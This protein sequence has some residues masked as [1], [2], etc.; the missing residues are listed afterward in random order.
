MI[1]TASFALDG[2]PVETE[3][4]E[5]VSYARAAARLRAGVAEAEVIEAYKDLVGRPRSPRGEIHGGER[6]VREEGG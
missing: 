5:A 6:E 4:F 2:T 1:R 3:E